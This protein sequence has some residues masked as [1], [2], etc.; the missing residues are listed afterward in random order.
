MRKSDRSKQNANREFPDFRVETNAHIILQRGHQFIISDRIF[1][2]STSVYV[3]TEEQWPLGA[4]VDV[5][6]TLIDDV[7]PYVGEARVVS[8]VAGMP[9]GDPSGIELEFTRLNHRQLDFR[10]SLRELDRIRRIAVQGALDVSS[11]FRNQVRG[12]KIDEKDFGQPGAGYRRPVMIVHGFM[13]TRGAMFLMEQRLKN[14]GFPV[15]SMPLGLINV[16]DIIVSA[17]RIAERIEDFRNRYH[18]DRINILAHSMGGLIGMYYIKKLGGAERVRGLV[19][20]GTPWFGSG[21]ASLAL[22]LLPWS[23]LVMKSIKQVRTD[24][25]FLTEL[26]EG[27]LPNE[28]EFVSILAKTDGILDP[29]NCVLPGARNIM[30]ATNHAGLVVST[31]AF[32]TIQHILREL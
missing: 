17:N 21:L 3:A 11:Y 14:L 1:I 31:K 8:L 22:A 13:G 10:E 16:N 28:V 18:L 27:P 20:I 5:E 30:I 9:G 24:S 7:H 29:K 12:N 6:F 2:S 32:T 23:G 19:S 25:D 15:F 4:L 26:L